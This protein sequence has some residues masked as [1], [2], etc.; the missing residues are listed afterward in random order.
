MFG[1]V[2]LT[3]YPGIDQYKYSGYG[4]GFDRKGFFSLGD[5]IVKNVTISGGDI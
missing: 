1:T 5:E 3:K 2:K 4:I